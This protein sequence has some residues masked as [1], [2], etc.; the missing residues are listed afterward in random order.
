VTDKTDRV[1]DD[2]HGLVHL[3]SA[4]KAI[5][6]SPYFQRLRHIKQL[7]LA[8]MV[9]PGADHTRFSHSIGVLA[10]AGQVCD[11]LAPS[12]EPNEERVIRMA[13]LL[14]D[15]G[16]FPLSHTMET[17]Y[18]DME[19]ERPAAQREREDVQPAAAVPAGGVAD[20]FETAPR[21]MVEP[22]LH[23]AFGKWIVENTEVPN[24]ITTILKEHEFEPSEIAAI[25]SAIAG[26]HQDTFINQLL[27]SSLDVDQMDYLIRDARNTGV[28]YGLYDIEYLIDRL[29]VVSIDDRRLLCVDEPALH[30][31][32]HYLLAKHFYWIQILHQKTRFIIEE[33]AASICR[34]LLEMES[35]GLP[36]FKALQDWAQSPDKFMWF[37]DSLVASAMRNGVDSADL[38]ED[39]RWLIRVLGRRELPKC[40]CEHQKAL[41]KNDAGKLLGLTQAF[42]NDCNAVASE[43][44]IDQLLHRCRIDRFARSIGVARTA[45]EYF[46]RAD[47]Q[48]VSEVVTDHPEPIRIAL[49]S[50]RAFSPTHCRRSDDGKRYVSIIEELEGSLIYQLARR[51][52]H[53]LRKY[54]EGQSQGEAPPD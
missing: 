18:S 9:F 47:M 54:G 16:H 21:P 19:E 40:V 32:E 44:A 11:K 6:D 39:T 34:R 33:I 17:A 38:D 7:G 37:D 35:A 28:G 1:Y 42:E 41:D 36:S 46:G 12:L 50:D 22:A 49:R 14:H 8:H 23:E 3:T 43:S 48:D 10:I 13:A 15:I 51:E 31:A 4:E 20:P 26:A 29:I 52:V 53:I 45:T 25:G 2:I 30:T 27:H 5:L 24:G